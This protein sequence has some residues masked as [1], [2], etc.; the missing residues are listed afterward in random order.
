[1]PRASTRRTQ[2]AASLPSCEGSG[3]KS[4]MYRL[5]LMILADECPPDGAYY[6]CRMGC[7]G[8]LEDVCADCW[9]RY[10]YHAVSDGTIDPYRTERG[11]P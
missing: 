4:S 8:E 9:R 6:L 7:Q 11:T 1:M 10:L 2:R 3:L 5:A